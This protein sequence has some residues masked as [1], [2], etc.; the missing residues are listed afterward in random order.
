MIGR[1]VV[2]HFINLG[3]ED[4]RFF[5]VF[6]NWPKTN[7]GHGSSLGKASHMGY[8]DLIAGNCYDSCDA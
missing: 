8:P 3:K 5:S 4:F 7:H 1:Y 6:C 2:N